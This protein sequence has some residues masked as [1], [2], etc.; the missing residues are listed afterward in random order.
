MDTL[1][2][3]IIREYYEFKDDVET[4]IYKGMLKCFGHIQS[5]NE[6]NLS[7]EIFKER[8]CS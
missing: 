5:L 1:R 2:N 6:R 3:N 7:K 4:N 8:K